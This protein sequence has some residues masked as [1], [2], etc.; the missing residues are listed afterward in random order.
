MDKVRNIEE[1]LTRLYDKIGISKDIEF[2]NKF[3]FKPNT[4]STWRKRGSIPYENIIEISHNANISLDYIFNG[5]IDNKTELLNYK[6]EI[7]KNLEIFDEK[8]IK[9]FY[10]LMEAEKIRN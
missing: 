3:D 9:Y 5:E 1:I 8:Q 6:E 7:I 10:Y 2:C 4:V